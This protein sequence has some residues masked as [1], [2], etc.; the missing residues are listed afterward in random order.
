MKKLKAFFYVYKNSMT[1]PKYYKEVLKTD[2][3]F[4]LKYYFMLVLFA[5]ILITTIETVSV[6]PKIKSQISGFAENARQVYPDD[7]LIKIEEGKW[8][9]NR[10]EPFVIPMPQIPNENVPE[11]AI[12][13][14]RQGTISDVDLFDTVVLV[15]DV[16]IVVRGAN[17]IQAR[18]L[19]NVPDIEVNKETFDN[20]IEF[21][22]SFT[23]F[24][25]YIIFIAT[26]LG[27]LIYFIFFRL[28]Y[29]LFLGAAIYA[30]S[31]LNKKSMN[32]MN[33]YRIGLHTMTLPITFQ[34]VLAL[35]RSS[36][37][38]PLW[39]F[40]LNIFFALVVLSRMEEPSLKKKK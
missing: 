15:N 19:D 2:L 10:E 5:S 13:F 22:F 31:L 4:S 26:L 16:N 6:A 39:F 3:N 28:F 7:L 35:V 36:L 1:S 23:R 8:S 25:P 20:F 34:V 24:L 27:L 11:N 40:I 38:L 21:L 30:L 9:V 29:S 37:R 18:S 33:A 32:Y 17:G 14:Y 12:V